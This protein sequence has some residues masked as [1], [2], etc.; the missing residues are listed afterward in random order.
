MEYL[1]EVGPEEKGMLVLLSTA[2][3]PC[4]QLSA[5]SH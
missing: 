3:V 2:A 5:G 1:D 4:S